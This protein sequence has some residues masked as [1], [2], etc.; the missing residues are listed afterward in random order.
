MRKIFLLMMLLAMGSAYEMKGQA[1]GD[2]ALSLDLQRQA[3]IYGMSTKYGDKEVA[4]N[5]LY[6]I[7]AINPANT[8]I[9]DSLALMYFQ[10][11]EYASS[12]LISQDLLYYEPNNSLA[13]EIAAISF[14]SLGVNDRAV[15]Y[16]EKLYL[17]NNDLSVL[18]QTAYLQYQLTRYAESNLNLDIILESADSE[19]DFLTVQVNQISTSQLPMRAGVYRLKGMIAEANDDKTGAREYYTKALELAPDFAVVKRQLEALD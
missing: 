18:Y 7:L 14:E 15:N 13:L 3:F 12:A 11:G 1:V 5:A 8:N 2:S 6:N 19:N 17:A 9:L 4:K 10:N 16:Y